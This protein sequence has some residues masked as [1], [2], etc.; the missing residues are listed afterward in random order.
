M[1]LEKAT[2][3]E[4]ILAVLEQPLLWALAEHLMLTV[5]Q[6]SQQHRGPIVHYQQ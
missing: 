1:D 5:L 6:L 3:L 4:K 2:G